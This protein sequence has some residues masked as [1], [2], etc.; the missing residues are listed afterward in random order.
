MELSRRAC[1]AHEE[2]AIT[3]TL[4]SE[5]GRRGWGVGRI[6]FLILALLGGLGWSRSEGRRS[7]AFVKGFR[8]EEG[9]REKDGVKGRGIM[10][11][12]KGGGSNLSL[13]SL[14]LV[15]VMMNLAV[16]GSELEIVERIGE[17]REFAT[18]NVGDMSGLL[19]VVSSYS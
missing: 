4:R 15:S 13:K 8:G 7:E 6:F 11:F 18:R 12:S 5:G 10:N 16:K 1:G 14:F 2:V 9:G 19:N 17:G 3:Q